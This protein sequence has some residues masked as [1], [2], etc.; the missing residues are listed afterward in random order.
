MK[1]MIYFVFN[2]FVFGMFAIAPKG[3]AENS[4]VGYSIGIESSEF[5][6]NPN[7][8]YYDLKLKPEQKV[9][10]AVLIANDSDEEAT[11]EIALNTAITNDNG[12][13]DYTQREKDIKTYDSTLKYKFS[14]IARIENNQITVPA[15]QQ[16]RVPIFV[17]MPKKSFDGIILGGIYV[18]KN[19]D[20]DNVKEGYS[21]RYSFV[22]GV[23]LRETD[24]EVQPE[25][26]FDKV[27]KQVKNYK[28]EVSAKLRNPAA[29]N[30]SKLNIKAKITD[31]QTGKIIIENSAEDRDMAPNSSFAYR[32]D[33]KDKILPVGKFLLEVE[34]QDRLGNH[35]QLSKKF[36]VEKSEAIALKQKTNFGFKEDKKLSIWVICIALGVVLALIGLFFVFLKCRPKKNGRHVNSKTR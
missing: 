7:V 23:V 5:Q 1:K 2:L 10:L 30:I 27:N 25:I 26:V 16:A 4:E 24:K 6:H 3:L 8:S 28:T 36:T 9:E 12:I 34:A 20:N 14:D 11:F 32:F 31:L 13:I 19:V 18:L 22:K 35:W 17:T 15:K 29:I 33:F 21:N